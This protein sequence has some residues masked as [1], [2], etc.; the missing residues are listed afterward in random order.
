MLELIYILK[1][2]NNTKL[3][4]TIIYS[5]GNFS[6]INFILLTWLKFNKYFVGM[7]NKDNYTVF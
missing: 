7:S 4:I 6:E 1:N 5:I 3:Y 2:F